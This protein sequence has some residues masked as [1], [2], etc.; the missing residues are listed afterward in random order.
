MSTVLEQYHFLLTEAAQASE[1]VVDFDPLIL[2]APT[3]AIWTELLRGS[4]EAQ[5][6]LVEFTTTHSAE[7]TEAWESDRNRFPH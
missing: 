7:L 5:T 3:H 4:A 6:A 2:D 1:A